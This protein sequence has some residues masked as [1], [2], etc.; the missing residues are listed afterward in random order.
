MHV[1]ELCVCVCVCL[2]GCWIEKTIF[3]ARYKF[4]C[5]MIYFDVA[6]ALH[7]LSHESAN[8]FLLISCFSSLPFGEWRRRF[9]R[10]IERIRF[11]RCIF[12]L[13]SNARMRANRCSMRAI[14]EMCV[15]V[16]VFCVNAKVNVNEESNDDSHHSNNKKT[17]WNAIFSTRA[18]WFQV[19]R[20]P[21]ST[22]MNGEH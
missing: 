3:I 13:T 2:C 14:K 1:V 19:N 10:H 21:T 15:F 17:N 4:A 5:K 20:W 22:C 6:F 7:V 12:G 16:L 8:L 18:L 9:F 11:F